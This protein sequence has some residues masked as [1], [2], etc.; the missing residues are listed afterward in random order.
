VQR[1]YP[2]R[3]DK[4]APWMLGYGDWEDRIAQ[5]GDISGE[6]VHT[7]VEQGGQTRMTVHA[8]PGNECEGLEDHAQALAQGYMC[9]PLDWADFEM[10]GYVQLVEGSSDESNWDFTW[11][12]ASGRHTG[13]G[14]L[15]GCWGAGYKGSYDY[16]QARVRIGK[17]SWHVNYDWRA[18]TD[19]DGGLVLTRNLDAWLGMKVVRYRFERDGAEGIRNETWLDLG[20]SVDD[21]GCPGNDW[22]LVRVEEDHPGDESWGTDASECMA[23]A[24][25]QIML[26]GGPHVTWRWDDT[27]ARLRLMDVREIVAPLDPPLP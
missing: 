3:L 26:W 22:Q 1:I 2:T 18:W 23:P 12:G 15:E 19:V 27:T 13:S 16:A 24:E 21:G 14:W 7:I 10:T 4:A 17:E 5:F 6:G 20:G 25:D 8:E 11:Y 9:S